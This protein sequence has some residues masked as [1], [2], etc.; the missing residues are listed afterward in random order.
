M[1]KSNSLSQGFVTA[2]GLFVALSSIAQVDP[3]LLYRQDYPG[4]KTL[5]LQSSRRV[6][7]DIIDGELHVSEEFLYERY[8]L[9]SG[10]GPSA[11]EV[12]YDSFSR[13]ENLKVYSDIPKKKL[14]KYKRI[15]T[16]EFKERDEFTDGIFHDDVRS[17]SFRYPSNEAGSKSGLAYKRHFEIPQIS[18]KHF[19]ISHIPALEFTFELVK[20]PAVQAEIKLF[21]INEDELEVTRRMEKG[22]EVITY[23]QKNV[24]PVEIPSD[25]TALSDWSPHI[26]AYVKSY[27][28]GG[29]VIPVLRNVS[30]L[31]AW[32]ET[33][34]DQIAP[35]DLN[36]IPGIVDALLV[37]AV[38]DEEKIRRIF[39]YVQDQ[40]KYVAFEDG[41]GG[42][43]PRN[44]NDVL[45]KR[46]GDCKD[47][48]NL[49]YAMCEYAG[50]PAYLTWV[51]TRDIPYSYDELPTPGVD[52]HMIL[53]AGDPDDPERFYWL[54]ATSSTVEFG[55][56]TSFI[57]GKEALV[58][59]APGEFRVIEVPIMAPDYN[60]IR[61]RVNIRFDAG[62]LSGDAELRLAGAF[63]ASAVVDFKSFARQ[64]R[65]ERNYLNSYLQ[66]GNNKFNL[67]DYTLTIPEVHSGEVV[68][69]HSFQLEDYA[70][71]D[72][73]ELIINMNIARFFDNDKIEDD[74]EQPR[75]FRFKSLIDYTTELELPEGFELDHLPE[76]RMFN[77]DDFGFK[78]TYESEGRRIIY[79]QEVTMNM[80]VL[81]PS[82]FADWNSMINELKQAYRDAVVL[83][84]ITEN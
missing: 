40:I 2:L 12:S 6:I 65:D 16:K 7:Y 54:D 74:R 8:H 80:I 52:N 19:F 32:Y 59:L 39:R 28:F 43:I 70:F 66:K 15:Y 44:A 21:N 23:R 24:T 1:R 56:P 68:I 35:C 79:R 55:V 34:I 29:E 42:L 30:D 13:I 18:S 20:H 10:R 14:G 77:S 75:S 57:Q 26:I 47:M 73:Q 61:E 78:F 53:T 48:S 36:L 84:R 49:M 27:E 11:D 9:E 62:K 81:Q 76:S 45:N 38:S 63:R 41:L 31:F 3:L 17:I 72:D 58:R 46:F 51:G 83:R 71:A 69:D 4:E 22:K 50:V 33:M 5:L 37:G 25:A 60:A 82:Q 67:S 64:S